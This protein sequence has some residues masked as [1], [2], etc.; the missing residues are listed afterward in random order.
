MS[1]T[2]VIPAF[3]DCDAW[4][5][6]LFSGSVCRDGVPVPHSPAKTF[7]DP[8]KRVVDHTHPAPAQFLDDAVVGNGLVN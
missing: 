6:L 2:R 7:H 1:S 3:R 4:H 8:V 5:C